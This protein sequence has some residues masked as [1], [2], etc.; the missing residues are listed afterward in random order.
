MCHE[1]VR[2]WWNRFGPMFAAGIGKKRSAALR[3]MQYEGPL[4]S[5]SG[6]NRKSSVGL[7]MSVVGGR[8]DE[9][10]AITDIGQQMSL[11]PTFPFRA[12][13]VSATLVLSASQHYRDITVI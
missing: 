7:G 9:N 13:T 5:E 6:H 3:P 2:F 12:C 10:S 1:T 11:P 8:A 4:M